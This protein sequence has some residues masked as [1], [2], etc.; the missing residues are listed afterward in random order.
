MS[1]DPRVFFKINEAA[2]GQHLGLVHWNEPDRWYHGQSADGVTM[3]ERFTDRARKVMQLAIREAQAFNHEYIGTEH[4]LLGLIEEGSGVA[5][6]VLKN[7]G[8]SRDKTRE[9]VR[10]L[11][12]TG[13]APAITMGKLP[14]TPRAKQVIEHA[15]KEAKQL[16]HNYV[17]TEHLLLGLL[18][19]QEGVASQVLT[20]L[21]LKP[22]DVRAEV[23]NLLGASKKADDPD[24]VKAKLIEQ[25]IDSLKEFPHGKWTVLKH[26]APSESGAAPLDPGAN[27]AT[28][29][30]VVLDSED[31]LVA[32]N[33]VNGAKPRFQV[34][35]LVTRMAYAAETLEEAIQGAY[36]L[37]RTQQQRLIWKA[38]V[39]VVADGSQPQ[40]V[41]PDVPTP[42]PAP[43]QDRTGPA[44]P[45]R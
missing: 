17:G 41:V 39:N 35:S 1:N 29:L 27:L 3:Y 40:R 42:T 6:F 4:I 45:I 12:Q 23:L 26:T 37:L 7:L 18:C 16:G 25:F 10:K 31:V 28:K 34:V 14:H 19:V 44:E 33:A 43:P 21:G 5:S 8:F 36:E 30:Q 22:E 13:P 15:L 38:S 9:E 2:Y 32:E 20:G 11:V 24:D